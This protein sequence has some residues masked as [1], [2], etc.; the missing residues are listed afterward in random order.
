MRRKISKILENF[1]LST[2]FD[3]QPGNGRLPDFCRTFFRQSLVRSVLQGIWPEIKLCYKTTYCTRSRFN[4]DRSNI[5][6]ESQNWNWTEWP[7]QIIRNCWLDKKSITTYSTHSVR[8]TVLYDLI[9][10]LKVRFSNCHS[11]I[12]VWQYQKSSDRN[13]TKYNFLL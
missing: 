7:I 8:G 2:L 4:S 10:T 9:S 1:H 5:I 6:N 12:A 11:V 3:H 13:A